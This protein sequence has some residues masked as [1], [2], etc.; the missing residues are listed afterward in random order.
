M[1]QLIN[2]SFDEIKKSYSEQYTLGYIGHDMTDKLACVALTCYITNELRKKD[3]KTTC[4]DVLL[5]VG[6]DLTDTYKN[7]FLKVLGAV[8][9][10]FMYGCKDFPSFG[11]SPKEMPKRLKLILDNVL[12]F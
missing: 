9:E 7:T 10:D 6:K 8:C 12:P 1:S 4:Y 2:S 5:K 3:S 11:I